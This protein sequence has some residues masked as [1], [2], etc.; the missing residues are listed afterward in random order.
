MFLKYLKVSKHTKQN[1]WKK[2]WMSYFWWRLSPCNFFKKMNLYASR[3]QDFTLWKR[4]ILRNPSEWLL[5]SNLLPVYLIPVQYFIVPSL[6]QFLMTSSEFTEHFPGSNKSY[7][8]ISGRNDFTVP[9]NVWGGP[10][11]LYQWEMS[12]LHYI[13]C[14]P[15]KISFF[16]G[17]K[18]TGICELV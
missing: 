6:F 4:P 17:G 12:T 1:P 16:N 18:S 3:F 8:P 15:L 14:F 7:Y 5:P 11:R 2:L 10:A 9:I 13:W